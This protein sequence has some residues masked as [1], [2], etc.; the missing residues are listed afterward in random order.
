MKINPKQQ[1][2]VIYVK[3]G[4]SYELGDEKPHVPQ[5][6]EKPQF[7]VEDD[8]PY[9]KPPEYWPIIPF[10][11]HWS[12]EQVMEYYQRMKLNNGIPLDEARDT[13]EDLRRKKA[14]YEASMMRVQLGDVKNQEGTSLT[15]PSQFSMEHVE[16]KDLNKIGVKDAPPSRCVIGDEID[17]KRN[18]FMDIFKKVNINI[19]LLDALSNMPGYEKFLRDVVHNKKKFGEFETIMLSEEC[20]AI[21][22]KKLT[23]KKNDPGDFIIPCEI[24]GQL[25]R[26]VLCDL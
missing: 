24:G 2:N 1:C 15:L 6:E 18:K 16:L 7:E 23:N 22:Q 12:K 11:Q 10:P 19:S 5:L 26:K 25:F 4:T 13:C 21:L 3:S 17:E 9:V 14:L 8:K 20:S